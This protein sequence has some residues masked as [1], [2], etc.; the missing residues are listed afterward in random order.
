MR[1]RNLAGIT[2][3][4][5]VGVARSLS[6]SQQDLVKSICDGSMPMLDSTM[7]NSVQQLWIRIDS[8]G[9]GRI[10][11]EDFQGAY[12]MRMSRGLFLY[13]AVVILHI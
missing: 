11:K 3:A 8:N 1:T 6:K 5:Q 4:A 10:T 2:A 12:V 9:D 7:R 13:P